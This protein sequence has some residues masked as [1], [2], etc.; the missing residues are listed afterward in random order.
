MRVIIF[1]LFLS[2]GMS[3]T[4]Q[5]NEKISTIE[6]VQVVNNNFEEAKFY[7]LN[8]W[9]VLREMA[10]EKMYIDSYQL[11]ETP[12]SEDAPFQIILVTTY[13]NKVQYDQREKTF[14]ELIEE[15]GGLKLMN[16]KKPVEFRKSLF[17][18]DKVLHW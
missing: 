11:L 10:V 3:L 5:Q 4:A 18:K 13:L 7:Y 2:I 1:L 12:F 15:K 17:A 8:N 14:S 9:K 16:E 6:F